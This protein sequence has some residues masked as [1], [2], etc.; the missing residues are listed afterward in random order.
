MGK[1]RELRKFRSQTLQFAG[2]AVVVGG[3]LPGNGAWLPVRLADALSQTLAWLLCTPTPSPK[4]PG[5]QVL[6]VHSAQAWGRTSLG[7]K[8]V[9]RPQHALR[10]M[11][12]P[13]TTC[14]PLCSAFSRFL[15]CSVTL[16]KVSWVLHFNCIRLAMFPFLLFS[17]LSV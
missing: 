12:S 3:A 13:G 17:N 1:R 6:S 5:T 15:L 16:W 14:L 2:Y 7:T 10:E 11:A 4:Q 8:A 9:T